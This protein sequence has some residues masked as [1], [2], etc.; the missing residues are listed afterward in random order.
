M[1]CAPARPAPSLRVSAL[2]NPSRLAMLLGIAS[3][4]FHDD[5]SRRSSH[6]QALLLNW[7]MPSTL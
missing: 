6:V 5:R 4:A 7:S 3:H 1:G 2:G